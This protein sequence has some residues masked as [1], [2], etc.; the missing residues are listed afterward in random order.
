MTLTR[1]GDEAGQLSRRIRQIQ[2]SG[3]GGVQQ[4]ADGTLVLL[5][6]LLQQR[7][8]GGGVQWRSAAAALLLFCFCFRCFRLLHWH[9]R[10]HGRGDGSAVCHL[11]L[12]EQLLQIGGLID[13]QHPSLSVA[14][15]PHAEQGVDAGG[16]LAAIGGTQLLLQ[17]R[18]LR[19]V[20]P[21]IGAQDVVY[22]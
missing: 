3:D 14:L 4:R 6:T 1:S 12:L 18:P 15:Q 2:T 11:H 10:L 21:V 9:P 19:R 8:G 17:L 13:A 5:A 7:V 22:E 16:L 20:T